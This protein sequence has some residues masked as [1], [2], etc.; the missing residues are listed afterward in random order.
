MVLY[1]L[2]KDSGLKV[3]DAKTYA[4]IASVPSWSKDAVLWA[5]SVGLFNGDQNGN[6]NAANSAT[7][8]E[9]AALMM[10]IGVNT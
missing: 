9:V 6:F 3:G 7:R 5:G 10:R 8:A 4:D 2:Y 1:R